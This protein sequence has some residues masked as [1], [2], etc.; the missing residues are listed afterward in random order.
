MRTRQVTQL[1]PVSPSPVSFVIAPSR[2][3]ING[4]VGLGG[5]SAIVKMSQMW[6]K[7]GKKVLRDRVCCQ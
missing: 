3:L 5:F 2:V 7:S 4:I 1:G 6:Q